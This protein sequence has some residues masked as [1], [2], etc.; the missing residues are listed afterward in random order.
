MSPSSASPAGQRPAVLLLALLLAGLAGPSSGGGPDNPAIDM[1]GYLREARQA[2]KH[3]ETRRLTEEEFLRRS[4]EP[5]AVVLDARSAD[6]YAALHVRG[7]LS[8]PFTDMTVESLARLLPDRS[9]TILI[10]CN[11]NFANAPE[12]FP[13]KLP[14]AS[15]N[16]STY[17]A[18]WS[19]GYRNVYELGPLVDLAR[20]KLPF[21]GS[22]ASAGPPASP[23]SATTAI[24]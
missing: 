15:L 6:K 19:Y 18:L 10:Y 7:A 23:T 2:A 17:I 21:E 3:R 14:T 12:P 8:L 9:T 1:R 20:S 13:T 16:L 11:N 24:P 5:G 4:R 22:G